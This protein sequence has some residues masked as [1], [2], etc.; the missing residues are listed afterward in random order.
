MK[1]IETETTDSSLDIFISK[2]LFSC[3]MKQFSSDEDDIICELEQKVYDAINKEEA[4]KKYI[5]LYSRSEGIGGIAMLYAEEDCTVRGESAYLD[6]NR[7]KRTQGW[8]DKHDGK[9]GCLI[10]LWH[11]SSDG[12]VYDGVKSKKSLILME[13]GA[14]FCLYSPMAKEIIDAYTI[15]YHLKQLRKR[16]KANTNV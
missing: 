10:I 8:I 1:E 4:F 16:I 6:G 7:I 11:N 3:L 9:Y 2:N 12:P 5:D 15:D 13:S 14:S